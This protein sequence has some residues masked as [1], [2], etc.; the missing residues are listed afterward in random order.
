MKISLLGIGF[1][2]ISWYMLK[3]VPESEFI[4][5]ETDD[6]ETLYVN[7]K[8]EIKKLENYYT[9]EDLEETK[10]WI[11]SHDL[12]SKNTVDY[13]FQ[14]T[15]LMR[16]FE[17][18]ELNPSKNY[19]GIVYNR[20]LESRD[21]DIHIDC[22]RF[23][24]FVSV[25]MYAKGIPFRRIDAH[26][27]PDTAIGAHSFQEIYIKEKDQ[28][29]L[30]DLTND[31]ILLQHD[32]GDYVTV[33]DVFERVGKGDYTNVGIYSYAKQNK[34]P[35]PWKDNIAEE[36]KCFVPSI[37]LLY[38]TTPSVEKAYTGEGLTKR[39]YFFTDW[40]THFNSPNKRSNLT[41]YLRVLL[42]YAGMLLIIIGIVRIMFR[43][44]RKA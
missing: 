32:N 12:K 22:G 28:W 7:T 3:N 30:V 9:N 43:W 26:Y 31:K 37:M 10:K 36:H 41:Y 33:K 16:R 4:F 5:I 39:R 44:F 2:L 24:D 8:K 23:T 19:K 29:A 14:V 27:I 20:I 38:Y 34:T 1:L 18:K 17:Q 35:I 13:L 25:F 21:A 6:L 40:I 15:N 11:E 42:L